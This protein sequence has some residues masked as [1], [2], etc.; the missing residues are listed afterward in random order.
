[1]KKKDLKECE[2]EIVTAP[3]ITHNYHHLKSGKN[4]LKMEK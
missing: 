3:K 4:N 1:M 2:G